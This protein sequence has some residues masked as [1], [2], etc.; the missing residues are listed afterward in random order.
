MAAETKEGMF[1]NWHVFSIFRVLHPGSGRNGRVLPEVCGDHLPERGQGPSH[2][3]PQ[4]L[5]GH[6]ARPA[7][8]HR[9]HRAGRHVTDV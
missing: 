7:G 8:G 3:Q 5:L 9:G 6:A 1:I 2:P 4:H